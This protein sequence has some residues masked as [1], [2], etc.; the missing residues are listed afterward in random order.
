MATDL[1]IS[2]RLKAVLPALTDE[3]TEQLTENLLSD[4]E[5]LAPICIWN[6]G[7]QNVIVD[8]MHSWPIILKHKLSY[9]TRV[10]KFSD[11]DAAELWILKHALGTRGI[12]PLT[13][14]MLRGRLYKSLKTTT[15]DK[16]RSPGG[17]FE[18]LAETAGKTSKI[19]AD[20]TGVSPATVK[21]DAKFVGLLDSLN[22]ALK[23]QIELGKKVTDAQLK[24]LA[25]VEHSIQ[26]DIASD[27]RVGKA[28]DIVTAAKL[29][30]VS[31]AS[32]GKVTP[33]KWRKIDKSL[34]ERLKELGTQPVELDRLREFKEPE[35]RI[36]V[37]LLNGM[38]CKTVGA[39]IGKF[40]KGG[41]S[42]RDKLKCTIPT[43]LR[44]HAA[45]TWYAEAEKT[46]KKF[47]VECR[48]RADN[49]FWAPIQPTL[50]KLQ[51]CA[52][53]IGDG[54]FG[55]VCPSCAGTG[56]DC[57]WCRKSGWMPAWALTDYRAKTGGKK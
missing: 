13:A 52:T 25:D 50:D 43:K 37:S 44:K 28:D 39:A 4:N 36:I 21:R 3:E 40:R 9:R 20:Q 14:K 17:Q 31:L 30:N 23:T 45:D 48:A 18:P 55:V 11:Y 12:D 19:I 47:I 54:A 34:Q 46:L 38:E 32:T 15:E 26:S 51:E 53:K 6:D 33:D 24:K 49:V 7:E 29:H 1:H 2:K 56:K 10:M 16:A 8:G 5:K 41:A 27:L 42:P 35:Q 22:P 57:G